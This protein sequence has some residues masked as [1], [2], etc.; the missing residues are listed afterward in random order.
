MLEILF[1]L[2]VIVLVVLWLRPTP[3]ERIQIEARRREWEIDKA[4][5]QARREMNRVAGQEWRNLVDR[6]R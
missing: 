4:A 2:L 6:K 5:R 3:E 1:A